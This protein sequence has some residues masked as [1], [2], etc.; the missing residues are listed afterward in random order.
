MDRDAERFAVTVPLPPRAVSPN[1]RSG[2]W[3]PGAR[4]AAE[5]RR[6]AALAALATLQERG[7]DPP[8]WSVVRVTYCW[9]AR[10]KPVPDPDNIIAR[11]K[12]CLDGLVDAGILADDRWVRTIEVVRATGPDQ[13][14]I[15]VERLRDEE[16]LWPLL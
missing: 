5:A 10:R 3:G 4:A 14:T 9:Q 1:A 7:L 11:A 15:V 2:H 16:E 8:R 6:T 13:L 12:P